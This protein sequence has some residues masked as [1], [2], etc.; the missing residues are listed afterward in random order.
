MIKK[1]FIIFL[2]LVCCAFRTGDYILIST[3]NTPVSFMTT[4]NLGNLYL[5][6]NNELRKYDQDGTLLKTFSDKS[7]GNLAFVDVSDPLKILL[8]YHDF[9]Q[10]LFL[11]NMLSVKGDALLLDDL[12]VLQPM[13]VCTSYENGFWVY[14]QQEFQLIRFDKN[15]NISNQSGNIVQLTGIKIK[16]NYLNEISDKVY[17]NDPENGI[18]VFDKFG[19][20]AKT[21]PFKEL[22]SFQIRDENII[23]STESQLVLY[24]FKTLELLSMQLPVKN[25][26]YA[27]FEKE[28]LFIQ[29]S[30][31]VKIYS[32]N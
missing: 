7:H 1:I 25:V 8:Y 10:V 30:A 2:L 4:D 24:N 22:S 19:T 18:L 13:L 11:D 32:N 28:R 5:I 21:L 6:V 27:R 9:R 17:L 29:D 20:Y 31:S 12:G 15:L 23:Y 16:P 3:I 14:D 26:R